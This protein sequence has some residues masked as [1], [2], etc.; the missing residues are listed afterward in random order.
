[1]PL[2]PGVKKHFANRGEPIK[3]CPKCGAA[4]AEVECSCLETCG[5]CGGEGEVDH[6]CD[7]DY[8]YET[9][10]C[11]NCDG[12]GMVASLACE[13]CSGSGKAWACQL[14]NSPG[15]GMR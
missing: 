5:D 6:D 4:C 11:D 14:E 10:D 13:I 3:P 8:C 9:Q 2:L 7:C 1:M 15:G 12:T